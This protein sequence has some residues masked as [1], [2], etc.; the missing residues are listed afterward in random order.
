MN[1]NEAIRHTRGLNA[2]AA[3]ASRFIVSQVRSI[4]LVWLDDDLLGHKDRSFINDRRRDLM[5]V[6]CIIDP[7]AAIQIDGATHVETV[8]QHMLGATGKMLDIARKYEP[9]IYYALAPKQLRGGIDIRESTPPVD[10]LSV[11]PNVSTQS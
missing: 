7:D 2:E 9:D 8:R 1:W 3:A 10:G 6:L 4:D 5:R 11:D